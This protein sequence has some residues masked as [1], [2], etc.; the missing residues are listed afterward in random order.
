M[1]GNNF[2]GRNDFNIGEDVLVTI[3]TS[4]NQTF[5]AEQLGHL[6]DIDVD[7]EDDHVQVKT[8]SNGGKTLHEVIPRGVKGKIDFVRMD[9]GFAQMVTKIRTQFQQSGVRTTF[10]IQVQIRN[11]DGSVDTYLI[12]GAKILNP[13]LMNT[14]AGKEIDTGFNFVAQ[15]CQLT[16]SGASII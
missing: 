12:T 7:Y 2:V 6:K 15:D 9:G 5:T 13:K 14:G 10:T 3:K 1:A 8:I 16:S 11:R 4:T